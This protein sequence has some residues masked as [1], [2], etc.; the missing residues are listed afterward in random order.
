M[1]KS[2]A[3]KKEPAPTKMLLT[4]FDSLHRAVVGYPAVIRPGKDAKLV[5]GL[6]GSH[7]EQLV[8]DLMADFF[9][10]KDPF[11]LQNG[12]S[13]GVFISQAAKLLARRARRSLESWIDECDRIHGG[14]CPSSPAHFFRKDREKDG[15][16]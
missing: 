3:D 6:W 8:R 7:G 14:Q 15:A 4:Y 5:A 1:T 11:I 10:S 16:A 9:K 12:Y 2:R 13:V